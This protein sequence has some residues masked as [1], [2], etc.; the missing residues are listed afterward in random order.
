MGCA[1]QCA[2]YFLCFFNFVFFVA[3][4]AALTVG[5][6]LFADRN[7]F[8]NLIA[9]LDQS[10][11]LT[12]TD[13]DVIRMMSYILIIAGALT[14]IVSFLGYC[15]A[16]FESRCLLCVY[17]VL[18]LLVLVLESVVV[19]LAFGLKGDAE[20]GTQSFLKSTIKYYAASVDQTE[21]VTVAWDGIMTQLHCCGVESYLDFHESTNW[22]TTNKV[23]PES[24][25]IKENGELKDRSC[26]LNPTSSNSYYQTGCYKAILTAI[27]EN[28]VIVIGVAAGLALV[29]ILVI[30]LA[31]YLACIYW[32]PQHA[33]VD[34]STRQAW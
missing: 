23:V 33:C 10:D 27:E 8:T 21:T 15:G 12:K 31:L 32:R 9:K 18:L 3:G 17:G 28:A 25:C 29:E 2:K 14:F 26:P 7:S 1:S 13:A 24:C 20:K 4:G 5:I 19:G 22:T 11:I 6:W 30:I 16:M 34:V